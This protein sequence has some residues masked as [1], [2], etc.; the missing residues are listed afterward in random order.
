MRLIQSKA[1][2]SSSSSETGLFL[3]LRSE[4]RDFVRGRRLAL[5]AAVL[6]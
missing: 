5:H 2:S 1:R 6:P 3:F 4:I